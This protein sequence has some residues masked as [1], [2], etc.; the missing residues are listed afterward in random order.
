MQ[1]DGGEGIS[2]ELVRTPVEMTS[3]IH[4]VEVEGCIK[5]GEFRTRHECVTPAGEIRSY[6]DAWVGGMFGIRHIG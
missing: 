2:Q 3:A 1:G 5:F 6:F 4:A